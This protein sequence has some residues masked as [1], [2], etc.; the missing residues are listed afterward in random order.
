MYLSNNIFIR[1]TLLICMLGNLLYFIFPFP[2]IIW[3]LFF[4]L[5]SFYCVYINSKKYG[6]DK[7]EKSIFLFII[8]NLVY[9]F[10]SYLWIIPSTTQLGNTLYALLAFIAFSFLGKTG[11]L[12]FKYVT[13]SSIL[14]V[15]AGIPAYY[16][17]QHI[18]LEK[19]ITDADE[20]TIN[21]SVIFLML[22][23]LILVIKNR[24]ISLILFC[25]CMF[26]II[27]GAKRGNIVSSFI[28]VI[29]YAGI[30]LKESR[31]SL[32]RLLLI[33]IALVGI[34]T[35]I[36][37]IIQSN[38]YLL[39][40]Y[41]DT[42]VGETSGR[43]IIY[44]TMWNLWYEADNLIRI[45]FGYGYDGTIIHSLMHKRAH[46]DWLEILVD[47]G[48]VGFIFYGLI[49]V[50]FFKSFLKMSHPRMRGVL[51]SIISIWF[52]KTLFSMGFTS[53]DLALMSIPFGCLYSECFFDD[54]KV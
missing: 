6:L 25:I 24:V 28:P 20:T 51:L 27:M 22:L 35:W 3:R 31:K 16:N 4:V 34:A 12:T 26:F 32:F 49:F 40:R 43:D 52:F 5:L 50:A 44:I 15:A 41:E 23:P 47:F 18:A 45:V 14:I 39:A 21:A 48:I 9:F 1:N 46:N 42:V 17:A 54:V 53:E 19:L 8:L 11:V 2:A 10:F 38:E 36:N 33:A 30:L 7:I 13:I 37:N 29:I